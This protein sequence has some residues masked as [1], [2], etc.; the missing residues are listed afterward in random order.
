MFV[1]E[2]NSVLYVYL[3]DPTTEMATISKAAIA[4]V[5]EGEFVLQNKIQAL[6]G[7]YSFLE[8]KEWHEPVMADVLNIP[9][10]VFTD[11][12]DAKNRLAVGVEKLEIQPLVE[13]QLVKLGIPREAVNIEETKPVEFGGLQDRNRPLVGGLQIATSR[14]ICSLG[15][16]AIRAGVR[17]FVANSHCTDNPGV[18]KARDFISRQPSSPV[19]VS[20]SKPL[21]RGSACSSARSSGCV[22]TVMPLSYDFMPGSRADEGILHDL[23]R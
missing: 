15:F 23:P 12:D 10:V 18:S 22:A 17:G 2:T 3:L 7:Q 4:A 5:F 19:I 8:L 14:F 6:P 11:I 16:P 20:A 13:E 21:T 9:G 1:D